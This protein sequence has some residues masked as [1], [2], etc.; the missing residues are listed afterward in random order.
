LDHAA[1]ESHAAP[2]PV[3]QQAAAP[4]QAAPLFA[5]AK[6]EVQV[7]TEKVVVKDPQDELRIKMLEEQRE[8]E[9]AVYQKRIEELEEQLKHTR[10]EGQQKIVSQRDQYEHQISDLRSEYEKQLE[11][12]RKAV[13]DANAAAA[14]AASEAANKPVE[15]PK[16]DTEKIRADERTQTLLA[17]VRAMNEV[18]CREAYASVLSVKP[19]DDSNPASLNEQ[20][21]AGKMQEVA[22]MAK[23][24]YDRASSAPAE[25]PKKNSDAFEVSLLREEN[26]KLKKDAQELQRKIDAL[27]RQKSKERQLELEVQRLE[28]ANKQLQMN[29]DSAN[30]KGKKK[31]KSK[32]FVH[33]TIQVASS[34]DI[35]DEDSENSDGEENL[36]K[37]LLKQYGDSER[38]EDASTCK[39]KRS[40]VILIAVSFVF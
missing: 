36:K 1:S 27:T 22:E 24:L 3:A 34:S 30:S 5:R 15:E 25:S 13:A 39:M 26:E 23:S 2:E 37:N 28:L 20:T 40:I 21:C 6:P 32:T 19:A 38:G 35:S 33:G 29:L 12:L 9:K 11:S 18:L 31:T 17:V 10:E 4:T 14:A 8:Q 16:I 7:V